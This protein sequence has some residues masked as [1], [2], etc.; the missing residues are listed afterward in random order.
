MNG[1]T[2]NKLRVMLMGRETYRVTADQRGLRVRSGRAWITLDGR[3]LV[4]QRGEEIA[5]SARH[6]DAVVSAAGRGPVVIELLGQAPRQPDVNLRP[7][8]NAL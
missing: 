2:S 8:V 7:A 5:L 6:D 4:L 3:D 1:N